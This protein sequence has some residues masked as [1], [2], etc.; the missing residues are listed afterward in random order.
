MTEY[1]VRTVLIPALQ[2]YAGKEVTPIPSW[3]GE[4]LTIYE[5][6][7]H[8][9]FQEGTFLFFGRKVPSF[10]LMDYEGNRASFEESLL[11]MNMSADAYWHFGLVSSSLPPDKH[12]YVKP[13][14]SNHTYILSSMLSSRTPSVVYLDRCSA[15][16][17]W[18]YR[19]KNNPSRWIKWLDDARLMLC[20]G[21]SGIEL[22]VDK[23]RR[24][25]ESESSL[26]VYR[27]TG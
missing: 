6:R 1:W 5:D 13:V 2:S 17:E 14:G 27:S 12:W 21:Y 3:E 4:S 18:A 16:I 19:N 10:S 11:V 25:G 22:Y 7:F 15:D 23:E 8:I 9:V 20:R 26:P 24:D